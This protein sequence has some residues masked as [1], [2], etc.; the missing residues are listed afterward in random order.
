[1]DHSTY[2]NYTLDQLKEALHTADEINYPGQRDAIQK[3]IHEL[4]ESNSITQGKQKKKKNLDGWLV[5][6]MI[7]LVRYYRTWDQHRSSWREHIPAGIILQ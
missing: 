1:M 4:E 5:L 6:V 2:K 7:G 3:R